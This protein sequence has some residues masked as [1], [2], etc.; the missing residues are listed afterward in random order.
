MANSV[1][2]ALIVNILARGARVVGPQCRYVIYKYASL[3]KLVRN[4]T[5]KCV[6]A[7]HSWIK[8]RWLWYQSVPTSL[9]RQIFLLLNKPA[10]SRHLKKSNRASFFC[11]ELS[12]IPSHTLLRNPAL[13][14][15]GDLALDVACFMCLSGLG[16]A[17]LG[18]AGRVGGT[19]M[20]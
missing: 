11:L 8:G 19:S 6:R 18:W 20:Q 4:T 10:S 17:G 13:V 14:A 1:I 3:R 16:W 7:T 12:S 9:P 5:L 15:L 2:V